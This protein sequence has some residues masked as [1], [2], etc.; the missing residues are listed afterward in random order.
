MNTDEDLLNFLKESVIDDNE[1]LYLKF[2]K[3]FMS[4]LARL[5]MIVL[6]NLTDTSSHRVL[7]DFFQRMSDM[8]IHIPDITDIPD[9]QDFINTLKKM[10][11]V[12]FPLDVPRYRNL[13]KKLR[14]MS[15]ERMA[16]EKDGRFDEIG[17]LARKFNSLKQDFEIPEFELN[18]TGRLLLSVADDYGLINIIVKKYSCIHII[19]EKIDIVRN[20]LYNLEKDMY[21]MFNNRVK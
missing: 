19:E 15:D 16:L 9:Y 21:A 20:D 5:K 8:N 14:E 11:D 2:I 13:F 1:K 3:E 4:Y 12:N 7:C 18:K 17:K 6:L 10:K